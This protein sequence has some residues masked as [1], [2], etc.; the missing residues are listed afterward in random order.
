M[1]KDKKINPPYISFKTFQNFLVGLG[2]NIPSRIDRSVMGTLS[3]TAQSQ[4]TGALKYLNLVS[5]KGLPTETLTQLISSE[6][7]ERKQIRQN[8]INTAYPYLFA[9]E[10][11]LENIT[12]NH[13]QE[14]FKDAGASG[15]T[16]RK[17]ISFFMA[18]AKSADIKLSPHLKFKSN[19]GRPKG[20]K[21]GASKKKQKNNLHGETPDQNQVEFM[22]MQQL[23][24]SKFPSFDPAWDSEVQAKWF[25]G[26]N[27]LME[28]FK[29]KITEKQEIDNEG[30]TDL[31]H[32]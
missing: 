2:V 31:E 29:E 12:L 27:K 23:L 28:Q 21:T 26:F 1:E 4:L 22:S 24:L 3:G 13:L 16:I 19:V 7:I 15:G 14:I 17:C 30:I 9:D 20:R 11:D 8:I 5:E 25:E 32:I 6:G 18:I 10:I